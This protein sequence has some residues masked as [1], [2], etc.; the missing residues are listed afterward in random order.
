MASAIHV[1]ILSESLRGWLCVWWQDPG[2]LK[3]A[4]KRWQQYVKFHY[5]SK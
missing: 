3:K 1:D 2:I 5:F 4:I